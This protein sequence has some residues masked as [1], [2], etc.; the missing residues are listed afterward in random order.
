MLNEFK[1]KKSLS[2]EQKE[3]LFEL[4]KQD[5][6]YKMIVGNTGSTLIELSLKNLEIKSLKLTS[7]RSDNKKRGLEINGNGHLINPYYV[8]INALNEF[9]NSL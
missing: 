9:I 4:L 2:N 1:E 8:D 6:V 5:P 7:C 3:K